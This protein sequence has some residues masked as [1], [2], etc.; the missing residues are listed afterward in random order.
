MNTKKIT[1]NFMAFILGLFVS[2]TYASPY[3]HCEQVFVGGKFNTSVGAMSESTALAMKLWMCNQSQRTQSNSSS[4]DSAASITG[5]FDGDSNYSKSRFDEW[6]Q[7]ACT[8]LEIANN[9]SKRTFMYRQ[10]ADESTI[11]AWEQCVAGSNKDL[12]CWAEPIDELFILKIK[13]PVGTANGYNSI[14]VD[15]TNGNSKKQ[16]PSTID[17]S[18]TGQIVVNRDNANN[19]SIILVSGAANS[20]DQ[21]AS[22]SVVIPP[23]PKPIVLNNETSLVNLGPGLSWTYKFDFSETVILKSGKI[24]IGEHTFNITKDITEGIGAQYIGNISLSSE[25]TTMTESERQAWYWEAHNKLRCGDLSCNN[26]YIERTWR[27]VLAGR[28]KRNKAKKEAHKKNVS[29]TISVI[30]TRNRIY[31]SV[32][33]VN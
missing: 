26:G 20:N 8:N 29:A 7:S 3:D 33:S 1:F 12:V 27:D 10:I 18:K 11:Q 28:N 6:K 17:E 25:R 23:I 19:S 13:S 32:V 30:D 2:A 4:F 22:C 16:F 9:S 21:Q 15:I 14:T 5:L 31:S 24:T